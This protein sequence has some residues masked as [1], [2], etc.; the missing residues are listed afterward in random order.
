[1]VIGLLAGLAYLL[2]PRLTFRQ[3]YYRYIYL[4]SPHWKALRR[5]KISSVGYRCE[6]CKTRG[7]LDVHHI[8]Y[9]NLGNEKLSQLRVLCRAC[10]RKEH[11]Q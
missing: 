7:R 10:H 2:R 8:H 1:M 5:L 9:R 4:R 11:G 3:I 6:K